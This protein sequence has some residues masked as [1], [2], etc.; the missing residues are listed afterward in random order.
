[1]FNKF[2]LVDI[3]TVTT[4]EELQIVS[5]WIRIVSVSRVRTELF[6]SVDYHFSPSDGQTRMQVCPV[7]IRE[8]STRAPS[9]GRR[10]F[11]RPLVQNGR[12]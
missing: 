10:M 5:K 9:R 12:S 2:L 8:R 7:L 4:I 1:M 3:K 11:S 6:S